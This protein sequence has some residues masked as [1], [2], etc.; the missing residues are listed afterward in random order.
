MKDK[1]LIRDN[2]IKRL[3]N[4]DLLV[5]DGINPV[6]DFVHWIFNSCEEEM[7]KEISPLDCLQ[8]NLKTQLK[9]VILRPK[10]TLKLFDGTRKYSHE[11]SKNI[12]NGFVEKKI[13]T[14]NDVKMLE[15]NL[16]SELEQSI[17]NNNIDASEFL[18]YFKNEFIQ[19]LLRKEDL[20]SFVEYLKKNDFFPCL[21]FVFNRSGCES[22][23]KYLLD[24]FETQENN[25]RASKYKK[26]IDQLESKLSQTKVEKKK[27]KPD[28][29]GK[30]DMIDDHR[31]EDQTNYSILYNY[32]DECVIS[33][34]RNY[35]NDENSQNQ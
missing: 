25:L 19:T 27:E 34:A 15:D 5:I 26:L 22:Y 32:L 11:I 7:L 6:T 20:P 18:L 9:N 16:K 28:K 12:F 24:F 35:S 2:L 17:G 33:D 8:K 21:V 23:C 14:R 29:N 30:R 4:Q 13:I 3:D 31:D 10:E 1:D